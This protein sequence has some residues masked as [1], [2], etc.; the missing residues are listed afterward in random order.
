MKISSFIAQKHFLC[1]IDGPDSSYSCLEIRICWKVEREAK[2]DPPIHTEYLRSG[3]AMILIFIVGGARA[4]ISFCIRSA[5]PG[6]I[7][8]PPDKTVFAYKSLRMSISHFM[9]LLYVVSCIPLDSF[10]MKAGWNIVS[11]LLNLSFPSVMT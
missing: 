2:M 8:V 10:P 7:A 4:E 9:I 3:G 5:T 1:T 11:W 6:N